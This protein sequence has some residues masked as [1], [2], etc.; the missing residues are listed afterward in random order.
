M[1]VD[2]SF[3]ATILET[4]SVVALYFAWRGITEGNLYYSF[5]STFGAVHL[6]ALQMTGITTCTTH[7]NIEL[8]LLCLV[9]VCVVL[10]SESLRRM[11]S[12]FFFSFSH[13]VTTAY[14]RGVRLRSAVGLLPGKKNKWHGG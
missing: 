6:S 4:A 1:K 2:G 9:Y 5:Y 3:I 11:L 8:V 7:H 10:S 14:L 13:L 12:S